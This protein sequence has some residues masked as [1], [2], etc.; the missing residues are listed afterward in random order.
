MIDIDNPPMAL[1]AV[2]LFAFFAPFVY[3]FIV[4]RYSPNRYKDLKKK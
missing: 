1:L 2:T 3:S 4:D